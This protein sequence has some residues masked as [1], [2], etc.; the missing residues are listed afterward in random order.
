MQSI[1]L[2]NV[3]GWV[4]ASFHPL[5]TQRFKWLLLFSTYS[6]GHTWTIPLMHSSLIPI[7]FIFPG[8]VLHM[9]ST[10][11]DSVFYYRVGWVQRDLVFIKL[12]LVGSLQ[13]Y[14]MVV[15]RSACL[16]CCHD[17]TIWNVLVVD[18]HSGVHSHIGRFKGLLYWQCS[19]VAHVGFIT[20]DDFTSWHTSCF[21]VYLL[22]L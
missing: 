21:L 1:C 10:V 19:S 7:L 16:G 11:Q 6:W 18:F 14:A 17:W 22:D 13:P 2:A 9:V 3:S 15:P 5:K 20:K 4:S 8:G 12:N